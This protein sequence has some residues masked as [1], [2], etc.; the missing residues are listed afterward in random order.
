MLPRLAYIS[1]CGK[2]YQDCGDDLDWIEKY[3]KDALPYAVPRIETILKQHFEPFGG[4]FT[5]YGIYE[6]DV[7]KWSRSADAIYS[8]SEVVE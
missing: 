5:W 6:Y 7:G 8:G 1:I 2:D 4:P 3:D